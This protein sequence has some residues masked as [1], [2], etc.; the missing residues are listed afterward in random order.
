M[1]KDMQGHRNH[2]E[3]RIITNNYFYSK[4]KSF[5]LYIVFDGHGGH[6]VADYAKEEFA[7]YIENAGKDIFKPLEN[8]E[9][10]D[11][12]KKYDPDEIASLLGE[13]FPKYDRDLMH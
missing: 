8:L 3:D 11:D 6:A 2:M 13:I 12:P 9:N 10:F 4:L 1:G 7:K 5:S